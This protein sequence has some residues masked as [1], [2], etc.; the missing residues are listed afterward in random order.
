MYN[1][2][3]LVD[4]DEFEHLSKVVCFINKNIHVLYLLASLTLAVTVKS[5]N[6]HIR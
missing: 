6:T 5:S 4:A 2:L 1:I 3:V